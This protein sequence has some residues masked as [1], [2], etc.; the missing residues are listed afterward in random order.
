MW[1]T[2]N[3]SVPWKGWDPVPDPIWGWMWYS[4]G[5]WF[6]INLSMGFFLMNVWSSNN[7]NVIN[8]KDLCPLRLRRRNWWRQN[9]IV[10]PTQNPRTRKTD[11]L[12]PQPATAGQQTRRPS[13]V[14]VTLPSWRG[15]AVSCLTQT[16]IGRLLSYRRL[17]YS[18]YWLFM[19]VYHYSM[20]AHMF[21]VSLRFFGGKLYTVYS[22]DGRIALLLLVF[23]WFSVLCGW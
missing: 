12:P 8:L 6:A 18:W 10:K 2:I 1:N 11:L 4:T 17:D 16:R 21:I 7:S 22:I 9:Q 23:G 15:I 5:S 20:E 19:T 13:P 3:S 14:P